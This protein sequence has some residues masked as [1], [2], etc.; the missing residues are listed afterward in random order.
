MKA[1]YIRLF[2]DADGNSHF[3][4]CEAE[5]G[6]TD[7][8]PGIPPL[9]VSYP[10]AA[11]QA[12]FFAAP[13]GWQSSWHPSSARHLFAVITG[14]WEIKVSD[15]EVRQFS[16]GAVV[17]VDD[18]SGKGHASRVIT[19]EDSLSLLVRLRE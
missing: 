19:T 7:F 18:T 12:S 13:A 1:K 8:A 10:F 15:G 9:L 3:E 5:L 4:D 14:A 11:S 2:S 16:V 6:E 17:L